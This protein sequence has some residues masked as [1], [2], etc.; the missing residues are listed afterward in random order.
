[1]ATSLS[2]YEQGAAIASGDVPLRF[3]SMASW[4][5]GS[6]TPKFDMQG[7]FDAI[8]QGMTTVVRTA[9]STANSTAVDAIVPVPGTET[10]MEVFVRVRWGWII[11]PVILQ[12]AAMVFVCAT[13][14]SSKSQGLPDWKS[15]PLAVLFFGMRLSNHVRHEGVERWSDMIT[16][17]KNYWPEIKVNQNSLRHRR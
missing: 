15:S 9:D 2:Y 4:D 13:V 16:L 5:G 7:I 17:A 6:P 10:A 3:Y 1:M 11:L 12:L 8:A 14:A